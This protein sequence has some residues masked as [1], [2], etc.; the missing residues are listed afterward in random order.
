M[1]PPNAVVRAALP[2]PRNDVLP[3]PHLGIKRNDV[4]S[5]KN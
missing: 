4:L 5:V 1:T 2:G 3:E